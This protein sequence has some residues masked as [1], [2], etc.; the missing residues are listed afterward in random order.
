MAHTARC[1]D[2]SSYSCTC[3]CGGAQHGAILTKGISSPVAGVQVQARRWAEERRWTTLSHSVQASTI[4]DNVADRQPAIRGVVSELVIALLE[5]KRDKGE[6]DAVAFLAHQITEEIGEEFEEHLSAQQ[7][8]TRSIS[9][10]W[11]V[12]LA[13]ICRIYDEGFNFVNTSIE[14]LVDAVIV[15]LRAEASRERGDDTHAR[16]IYQHKHIVDEAFDETVIA[17][18]KTLIKK[19]VTGVVAAVKS[20]GEEAVFKHLR[21]IAAIICPNPDRHPDIIKY[22]VWPLLVGPLKETIEKNLTSQM[23]SWLRNA[24]PIGTAASSSN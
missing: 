3:S 18:V 17:F 23:H 21:L 4:D 6:I 1:E 20:I 11:C 12:V 22:C 9:H 16:D 8:E 5:Q 19:A 24:Y 10:L 13:T 7:D 15:Q 14:D 2:A